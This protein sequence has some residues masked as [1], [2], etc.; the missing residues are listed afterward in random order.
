MLARTAIAKQDTDQTGRLTARDW[1]RGALDILADQGIAGVRVEP[2]AK[3]LGVTKGSFYWHFKDRAALIDAMLEGWRKRA[4]LA[5]IDRLEQS[6][7]GPRQ[8]LNALLNLPLAG[9]RS[10]RGADVE[11][12]IRLWG[13][14]DPKAKAALAEVDE[15]RL[16]YFTQLIEALGHSPEHSRARAVLA[17]SFM[18]VAA[19]LPGG[20]DAKASALIENILFDN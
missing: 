19:A 2:L 7:E 6:G 5:I 16:R 4:T 1:I 13:R 14:R 15:L 20:I 18:R 3:H 10:A 11:L 17:Y 9:H 12:A 8:R